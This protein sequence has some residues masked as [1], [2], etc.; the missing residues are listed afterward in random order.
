MRRKPCGVRSTAC[1]VP[2][3]PSSF[4]ITALS[5]LYLLSCASTKKT[6]T[7]VADMR[8]D[9]HQEVGVKVSV[10]NGLEELALDTA[11]MTLSAGAME[12]LPEGA[13]Y[14][15]Q[16]GNTRVSASKGGGDSIRI[17]ATGPKIRSGSVKVTAEASG[18]VTSS[19]SARADASAK[20]H[21][22]QP[23]A[24]GQPWHEYLPQL[25]LAALAIY[26]ILR[27]LS[28]KKSD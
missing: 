13:E 17:R 26:W 9:I 21:W 22:E 8:K 11:T 1:R 23:Q 28:W 2:L 27:I 24:R 25:L 20:G 7:A 4:V 12:M 16:N 14:S 5:A 15:V 10:E 6:A 19:D 18:G 3:K